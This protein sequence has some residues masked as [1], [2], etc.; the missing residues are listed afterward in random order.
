MKISIGPDCCLRNRINSTY[1]GNRQTQLFDWV[2]SDIDTLVKVFESFTTGGVV[3]FGVNDWGVSD[4][5]NMEERKWFFFHKELTFRAFHDISLDVPITEAK[6]R[7]ADMYTRRYFRLRELFNSGRPLEFYMCIDDCNPVLQYKSIDPNKL[8]TLLSFMGQ[9]HTLTVISPLRCGVVHT[10]FKHIKPII[11][12][13]KIDIDWQRNHYDWSAIFQKRVALTLRGHVRDSFDD[14]HLFRFVEQCISQW[15]ANVFITTFNVKQ[16]SVSYREIKD[17]PTLI[18]KEKILAY[19]K[20]LPP[21]HFNITI[22]NEADI[23]LPG[24]TDGVFGTTN[25]PIKAVK[26]MWRAIQASVTPVLEYDA[27][28]NTRLDFFKIYDRL[29][30]QMYNEWFPDHLEYIHDISFDKATRGRVIDSFMSHVLNDHDSVIVGLWNNDPVLYEL[31]A[32]TH[33]WC[34]WVG[35]DNFLVSSPR[36]LHAF[37][38]Y[39][40]NGRAESITNEYG[41]ISHEIQNFYEIKKFEVGYRFQNVV[42]G[43]LA[44]APYAPAPWR[45]PPTK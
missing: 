18:T 9:S 11:L 45:W 29:K 21:A 33:K 6:K 26:S 20:G 10:Q 7:V 28:I 41:D 44:I 35:C 38:T 24:R 5:H 15:N 17:D 37:C 42:N 40:L 14:K 23:E 13:G 22:E 8:K 12:K 30:D 31:L 2:I 16:T 19:F 27:V 1:G 32:D 3:H 34:T 36:L 43:Q 39:Y 25:Q 4:V